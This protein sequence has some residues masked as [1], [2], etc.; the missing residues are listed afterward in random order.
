M[1]AKFKEIKGYQ[2]NITSQLSSCRGYTEVEYVHL[3]G[4]SGATDTELNEIENL[5]KE[6]VII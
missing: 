4:I 1:P 6:G 3:T 5:L 2:S